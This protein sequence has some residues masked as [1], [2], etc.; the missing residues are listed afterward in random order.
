MLIGGLHREFSDPPGVGCRNFYNALV[1]HAHQFLQLETRA[2][3]ACCCPHVVAARILG[4]CI[5]ACACVV[6][7]G[8]MVSVAPIHNTTVQ[9][10]CASMLCSMATEFVWMHCTDTSRNRPSVPEDAIIVLF[11]G[12]LVNHGG[13]AFEVAHITI[14]DAIANVGC[15]PAGLQRAV[16]GVTASHVESPLAADWRVRTVQEL[17]DTVRLIGNRGH[18]AM[19]NTGWA[20]QEALPAFKFSGLTILSWWRPDRPC[21]W[22]YLRMHN[23]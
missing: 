23:L 1:G 15:P 10:C 5:T 14:G 20:A 9:V 22:C 13:A 19:P 8:S 18:P 21:R 6:C 16:S 11:G 4:E 17:L 7:R 12:S 2:Q 3:C